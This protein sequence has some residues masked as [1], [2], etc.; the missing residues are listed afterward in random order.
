M[1]GKVASYK[2]IGAIDVI[3][4]PFD[5]MTLSSQVQAIREHCHG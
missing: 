5:P 2:E 4:K 3:S 1:T